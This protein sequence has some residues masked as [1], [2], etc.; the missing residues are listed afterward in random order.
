MAQIVEIV[1]Y[2]L[3]PETGPTFQKNIV[4]MS[5]PLHRSAGIDV[6]AFGQSLHDPESYMLVRTFASVDQMD[7]LLNDF[8]DSRAWHNGP[9]D[10][11]VACVSDTH[12]VVCRMNNGAIKLLRGMKFRA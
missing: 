4:N 6:V 3:H 9:R 10:G 11:I 7:R 2:K 5:L 8:Y 1:S 12:R